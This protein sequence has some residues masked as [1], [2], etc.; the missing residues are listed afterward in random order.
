MPVAL[1]A[2]CTVELLPRT[3]LRPLLGVPHAFG[4]RLED[5]VG[6]IR[7]HGILVPLVVRP[8]GPGPVVQAGRWGRQRGYFLVDPRHRRGDRYAL[9]PPF[10]L[11][12]RAAQAALPPDV[13]W[14][15]V[16]GLGRLAAARRL[17]LEY[18]PCLLTDLSDAQVAH[19][20]R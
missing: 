9:K 1:T 2:R 19:V 5:L 11:S 10:Y 15:V 7:A 18:V 12:R 17:R 20:R 16:Q 6:S 14:E 8:A 4:G 3:D 13:P